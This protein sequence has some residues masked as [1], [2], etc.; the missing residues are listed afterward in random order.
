MAVVM[1]ALQLLF[2]QDN[3]PCYLRVSPTQIRSRWVDTWERLRNKNFALFTPR[4]DF[5]L[6]LLLL[7]LLD[8][9]VYL[10]S[11]HISN[12]CPLRLPHRC[13]ILCTYNILLK[14]TYSNVPTLLKLKINHIACTYY[15]IIM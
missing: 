2:V 12:L 11:I 8:R 6:L 15:N 10:L 4:I 14:R 3:W 1:F 7:F 9:Y 13:L 5:V